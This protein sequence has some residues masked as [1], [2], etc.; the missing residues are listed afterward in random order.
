MKLP[1]LAL[2]ALLLTT[3]ATAQS[4]PKFEVFTGYSLEHISACGASQGRNYIFL[5]CSM[6]EDGYSSP[7]NFNG[8]T[9]SLTR[10][11]YQFVGVTADFTGHYGTTTE[12][13][14]GT[15]SAFTSRYSYMFGPAAAFRTKKSGTLFA[16]ALFGG[17]T[18]NFGNVPGGGFHSSTPE[19]H[20]ICV[21]RRR[22]LRYKCNSTPG[23]SSSP[24]R[25]R[26]RKRAHRRRT[27][28][29]R[30][31]LR[32]GNRIEVLARCECPRAN[33]FG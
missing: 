10:Y 2:L 18:N 7:S 8:W 6:I 33:A 14:D 22:G 11:V 32:H 13:G 31:P 1:A 15:G 26:T 23:S 30:L 27:R 17:V 21:D 4:N 25:L 24:T 12:S 9:A 29:R 16:H 28:G 19:L 20:S 3:F 5:P